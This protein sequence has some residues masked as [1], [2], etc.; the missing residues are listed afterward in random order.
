[1]AYAFLKYILPEREIFVF[2]IYIQNFGIG[3]P[4]AGVACWW[5]LGLLKYS[6]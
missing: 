2:E 4:P 6:N 3:L 1:M 5:P